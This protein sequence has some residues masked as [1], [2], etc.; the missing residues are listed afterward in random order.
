MNDR[1]TEAMDG[2]IASLMAQGLV[3]NDQVET[4]LGKLEKRITDQLDKHYL[5]Y[6]DLTKMWWQ[7]LVGIILS[8]SSDSVSS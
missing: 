5:S 8:L 4:R 7:V 2:Q 1:Q 3:T 6:R